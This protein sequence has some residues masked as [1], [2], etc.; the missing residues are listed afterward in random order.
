MYKVR[1]FAQWSFDFVKVI[2]SNSSSASHKFILIETDYFTQWTKAWA[3]KNY[4][5][6]VVIKFLHDR[7]I[8][9]FR[10]PFTLVCENG[11]DFHSTQF[12]QWPF[13]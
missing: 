9:M 8:T 7:I 5:T 12:I 1:P 6:D 4:T 3:C 2:N 13:E 11:L 10:V